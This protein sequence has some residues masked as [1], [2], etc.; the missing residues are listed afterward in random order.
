V[1]YT[2]SSVIDS[3]S[4]EVR[5]LVDSQVEP[6]A[7]AYAV[8]SATEDLRGSVSRESL[9]EMAAKLACFRLERAEMVEV[10]RRGRTLLSAV[11]ER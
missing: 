1:A 8:R 5:G 7:I 11:R 10:P 9:P 2:S 6:D 4:A 3:I